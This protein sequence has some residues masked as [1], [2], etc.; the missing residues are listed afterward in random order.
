MRWKIL[1]ALDIAFST[2]AVITALVL[3][4]RI[5]ARLVP[6]LHDNATWLSKLIIKGLTTPD[7]VAKLALGAL[8]ATAVLL[9]FLVCVAAELLLVVFSPLVERL[10]AFAASQKFGIEFSVAYQEIIESRRIVATLRRQLARRVMTR[11]FGKSLFAFILGVAAGLIAWGI[12]A[13]IN[14]NTGG[15]VQTIAIVVVIIVL[16][17]L[18]EFLGDVFKEAIADDESV[19]MLRERFTHSKHSP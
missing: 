10:V 11:L 16:L 6:T 1:A 15:V 12:T 19:E 7:T 2:I 5:F 17:I 4:N 14:V 18:L 13:L 8:P 9:V 3:G